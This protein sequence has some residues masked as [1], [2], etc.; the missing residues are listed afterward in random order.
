MQVQRWVTT[1]VEIVACGTFAVASQVSPVVNWLVNICLSISRFEICF[2]VENELDS[3]RCTT[4]IP[5]FWLGCSESSRSH[6]YLTKILFNFYCIL[7]YYFTSNKNNTFFSLKLPPVRCKT[8][9]NFL[10]DLSDMVANDAFSFHYYY[11][12][13]INKTQKKMVLEERAWP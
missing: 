4:T 5:V 6:N 11:C 13:V 2:V 1:L 12:A 10:I 7:I 9:F 3:A 8:L